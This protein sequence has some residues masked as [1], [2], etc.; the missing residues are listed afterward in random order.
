LKNLDSPISNCS[1]AIRLNWLKL[2]L[3]KLAVFAVNQIV[4]KNY[5]IDFGTI[6]NND[7]T[8]EEY[9][10]FELFFTERLERI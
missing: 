10:P 1:T 5:A 6:K 2:W 9:H 4:I 3:T 8:W 7:D